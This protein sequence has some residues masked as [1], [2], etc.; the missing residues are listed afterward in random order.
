[1]KFRYNKTIGFLTPIFFLFLLVCSYTAEAQRMGGR[2]GGMNRGGSSMSRPQTSTRQTASTS[3]RTSTGSNYSASKPATINGG[4]QS[5]VSDRSANKSGS[6]S[7]SVSDRNVN[8]KD[9]QG[10]KGN[11]N[12]GRANTKDNQ[13][14]DVNNNINVN[15]NYYVRYNPMPYPRP[16]YA[17]GGYHY[18]CYHPYHYHPYHPYYWGPAYHPYGFFL[19]A[20]TTT[21]IIISIENDAK[22]TQEYYYDNGVYYVKTDGGYKV[23]EAPVGATVKEIPKES[24]TVIINETTN[25]YYYGGTY[26]EK[27]SKGYEVVP[28]MAGT[29]VENLPE[30]GEEV[31]IGEVTYVKI[32]STYYQPIEQNGKKMYE[33]VKVEE[34]KSDT[35]GK[36]K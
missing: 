31:K 6:G 19:V 5:T 11:A 17:Y 30:G 23:V 34:A 13:G 21:A 22:N 28:P 32:G 35:T 9:N 14:R 2:G 8:T 1:M 29:V 18:H 33:V 12:S 27:T 16:P 15:N 25:N 36:T 3:N 4:N 26:Y 7:A 20:I 10:N 24:Q